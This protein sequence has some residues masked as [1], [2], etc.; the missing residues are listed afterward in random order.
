MVH[1]IVRATYIVIITV[2]EKDTAAMAFSSFWPRIG[3]NGLEWAVLRA[4]RK[5][6]A[7]MITHEN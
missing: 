5:D 6:M 3:R 4:A 7:T 2:A 1:V